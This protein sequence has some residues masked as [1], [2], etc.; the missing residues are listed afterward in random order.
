M[1]QT[2][3][4]RRVFLTRVAG[5]VLT[6]GVAP[7]LGLGTGAPRRAFAA[8]DPYGSGVWLS[9]DHHIH[10]QYSIDGLYGIEEQVQSA[11]AGGLDFC[12][13]TDHG[14]PGH[15]RVLL[16]RAYPQLV[17]AR[18]RHPEITVFQGLEWNI[19][20]AEHGSIIMPPSPDEAKLLSEF[21]SRFDQ[22]ATAKT[23]HPARSEADAIAGV[24]YL[25]EKVP[26]ALFLANHPARRGL[27]SPHELRD[28][29]DAGPDVMRGFEGAPGHGA[30][31]LVGIARGYYGM[32]PGP[33][34]F[35]GYPLHAYRTWGGYDYYTA[36]VGGLWDSLLGEGRPFYITAN[37]DAHRYRGDLQ[38]VDRST[39]HTHGHVTADPT[40]KMPVDKHNPD[41]DYLP[42]SYARTYV[43][44]ATR[45]PLHILSG[46]R[47]GNMWTVQGGLIEGFELF[48]HDDKHAAPM[49]S[50][51]IT[52]R[53]AD[54][55]VVVRLKPARHKNLGGQ[56]PTLH[57][58]D[59]ITGR[60]SGKRDGERDNQLNLSAQVLAQ[61]VPAGA[62]RLGP[63]GEWLEF[64]R[65]FSRVQDS[66]Y[67]RVRGTNTDAVGPRLDPL[68]LDP[69]AEL[70]FYSN[71]LMVRVF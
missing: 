56:I 13:I 28:W 7:I 52:S 15:D 22:V 48:V 43:H 32:N 29:A 33:K 39:Y 53:G 59:L 12:V 23:D 50:T 45:E 34:A 58:I 6:L 69:F 64:R 2:G 16:S 44:A 3:S 5:Q 10:T 67:L 47:G 21:E 55:E 31:P 46:M 27:D 18:R 20:D 9:G 40:R 38:F 65:R 14:G 61:L 41:E 60:I 8:R 4:S 57:H 63:R 36:Q 35:H 17:E 49:G 70:W 25:Q 37:S 66:F 30:A 71:P 19:P 68:G 11:I 54:L 51:L 24:R 1:K 62:Q 42:G 26:K